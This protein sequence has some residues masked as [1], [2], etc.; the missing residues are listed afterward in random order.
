MIR[1]TQPS[2]MP[3]M[4]VLFMLGT[5]VWTYP[6]MAQ[7]APWQQPPGSDRPNCLHS[8]PLQEGEGVS[9]RSNGPSPDV[10]PYG[11]GAADSQVPWAS[12]GYE[13]DGAPLGL[14]CG[15]LPNLAYEAIHDRFW[16]RGEFLAWWTKGFATPPLLTSSPSGTSQSQA[17]V[18]GV[19]GT[20]ILLGGEDLAGG[21]RPGERISFGAWLNRAQTFGLEGSYLQINRQTEF[22]NASSISSPILARPFFNVQTGQQDSQ[23]VTYPGVQSGSFSSAYASDF[24]VA[25]FLARRNWLQ[26]PEVTV[27]FLTGY[28][29]QQ[30]DDHLAVD[31]S[32]SFSGTQSGFPAGST[33]QQSDRFDTRNVF[34]GGVVGIATSMHRQRW[35][36][37]T[38]L[39]I[40]A[41]ATHSRVSIEGATTT[42]VP[43]QATTL[44]PGGLLALPSNMGVYDSERF[45]VVPD[46]S[47]TVGYDFS[48]Q[49]RATIGYEMTYWSNVA[50]PGDQIDLNI[51]PRQLPP[52]ASSFAAQPAF[53]LRTSEYWAQGLNLGLDMKF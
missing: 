26:R 4:A 19:A 45:S 7:L 52:P 16:L 24:Q 27:D 6:A 42:S 33:V 21:F 2:V 32:L 35:T 37:D 43:G 53:Q 14:A 38:S 40:A 46:L 29:Y 41:G 22:F 49:V 47:V 12:E 1:D 44:L 28:R 36:F 15:S 8:T 11:E 20:S 10:L 23:T 48:P 30:L 5:G 18:L 31:D 50:R 9:E 17:G 25:E 51:D 13:R 3:T 39:K 34:Q